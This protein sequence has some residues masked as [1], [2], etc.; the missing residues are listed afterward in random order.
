VSCAQLLAQLGLPTDAGEK[1]E[2]H[3][4][5]KSLMNKKK[6]LK[7]RCNVCG[8]KLATTIM[9]NSAGWRSSSEIS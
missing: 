9:Q 1:L 4:G 3:A 7:K 5:I 8:V 2:L 6:N